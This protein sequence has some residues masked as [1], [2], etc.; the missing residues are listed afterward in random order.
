MGCGVP[1]FH[2]FCVH[3][4]IEHLFPA[5]LWASHWGLSGRQETPALPLPSPLLRPCCVSHLDYGK[6]EQARV[7]TGRPWSQTPGLALSSAASLPGDF[8]QET[9]PLCASVFSSVRWGLSYYLD[10]A[11]VMKFVRLVTIK[12]LEQ[13]LEPGN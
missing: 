9:F 2:L 13:G 7:E 8:G 10:Y 5:R 4:V 6:A 11:V 12:S 1:S 3:V